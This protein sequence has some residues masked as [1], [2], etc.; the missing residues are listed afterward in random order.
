[1]KLT[2]LIITS[3]ILKMQ[4]LLSALVF[5]SVSI[6]QNYQ[7][8]QSEQ[9]N[10]Y[11][12]DNLDY[13]LATRT[14]SI[15]LNGLDSV[16]YSYKTFR[17]DS[18]G[19]GYAGASW[20][21]NSVRI[22][23]NGDN[24]FTNRLFESITIKTQA[25]LNDTFE[26]YIYPNNSVVYGTVSS[27]DTMTVLETLDSIKVITLFSSEPS[28][29]LN[30]ENFILS[31]NHGFVQVFP[32]YYF[33]EAYKKANYTVQNL[34]E[35][36]SPISL[37]GSA[38]PRKGK[39][40][41][42]KDEMYTM[43]PN[44]EVRYFHHH[45]CYMPMSGTFGSITY[46]QIIS[47]VDRIDYGSDSIQFSVSDLHIN[48]VG[49]ACWLDQEVNSFTVHDINELI[50]PYLPEEL[51]TKT[52]GDSVRIVYNTMNYTDNCGQL[53]LSKHRNEGSF[54]LSN[55][56]FYAPSMHSRYTEEWREGFGKL[57]TNGTILMPSQFVYFDES[58]Y[59]T[60]LNTEECG[61]MSLSVT[62]QIQEEFKINAYPNPTDGILNIESSK[63]IDE[64][65]I[66][67]ITG[68]VVFE[69]DVNDF[70]IQM[71]LGHLRDGMYLMKAISGNEIWMERM[72]I[73]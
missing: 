52:P 4:L 26:V 55:D 7:T 47:V 33:P 23:P 72:I 14:D 54:W 11:G 51:H 65:V 53:T 41:I 19:S 45:H 46:I 62:E 43:Q 16:F 63:S 2:I 27:I 66:L 25:T 8:I 36:T 20:I 60:I 64:I 12:T 21:G 9:I 50:D 48:E 42:T 34:E 61:S 57:T 10:Y 35:I 30:Q 5:S 70:E 22:K 15:Q 37:V 29:L 40:M 31:K 68:K 71:R 18:T 39:N 38:Y 17:S 44:D 32:F 3:N 6:A 67:D 49:T 59:Y 56:T 69:T 1:M 28:F 24:V 58:I 73:K 13:I